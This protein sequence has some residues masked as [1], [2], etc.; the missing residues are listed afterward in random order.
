MRSRGSFRVTPR[1]LHGVG[2]QQISPLCVPWGPPAHQRL[3]SR[4]QELP[5]A[6]PQRKPYFIRQGLRPR[7]SQREGKHRHGRN[8]LLRPRL[9]RSQRRSP[10][11]A[12]Q[13]RCRARRATR[14]LHGHSE[15]PRWGPLRVHQV[16]NCG[17]PS[18]RIRRHPSQ[19]N[20]GR[21]L[22]CRRCQKTP[23]R[24]RSRS[25]RPSLRANRLGRGGRLHHRRIRRDWRSLSFRQRHRR[26]HRLHPEPT[27]G[28][29]RRIRVVQGRCL[30]SCLL[31]IE[32]LHGYRRLP[33]GRRTSWGSRR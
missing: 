12:G 6:R 19:Q 1:D 16:I 5:R 26:G 22:Q 2:V 15:P 21:C 31:S 4:T 24:R 30:R 3:P 11:R 27:T 20:W 18:P 13:P 7:R 28:S 17:K 29:H 9:R 25:R 23:H 10:R 33:Q 8:Q 14:F 32:T